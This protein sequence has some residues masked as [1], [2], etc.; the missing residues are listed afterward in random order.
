MNYSRRKNDSLI[1]T[2]L[3][4]M[5][6]MDDVVTRLQQAVS[7][8]RREVQGLSESVARSY[9]EPKQKGH[10][11]PYNSNTKPDIGRGTDK[12]K[13]Q[14]ESLGE[15]G[16]RHTSPSSNPWDDR[17]STRSIRRLDTIP[18]F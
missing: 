2:L 17:G 14:G 8:L 3:D 10:R 6:K 5:K 12:F 1:H 13:K 16:D 7:Q 18:H 15:Q 11:V 4:D 9:D